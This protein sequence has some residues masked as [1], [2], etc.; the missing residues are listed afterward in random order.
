MNEFIPKTVRGIKS[1]KYSIC[2]ICKIG[3]KYCRFGLFYVLNVDGIKKRRKCV[4][5][6]A[7]VMRGF[8]LIC[9]R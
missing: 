1:Y 3:P 7:N 6:T 4:F 9:T 2:K 8:I 5:F